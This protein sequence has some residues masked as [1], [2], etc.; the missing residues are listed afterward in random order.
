MMIGVKVYWK[1][2]AEVVDRKLRGTLVRVRI[3]SKASVRIM[4]RGVVDKGST[5][6]R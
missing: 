6:A 5:L 4:V 2:V 1:T 3:K